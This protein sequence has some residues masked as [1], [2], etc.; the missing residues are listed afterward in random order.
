MNSHTNSETK[1]VRE[2]SLW[3]RAL[4]MLVF[5]LAFGISESV[6]Y[7]LTIIGLIYRAI[8]GETNQHLVNFGHSLGQYVQQITDY[9]SFN[10]DTEPFPF[11]RWPGNQTPVDNTGTPAAEDKPSGGMT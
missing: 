5:L 9:L 11:D 2:K 10:T 4:Y 3:V 6:L 8:K 1:P 7:L